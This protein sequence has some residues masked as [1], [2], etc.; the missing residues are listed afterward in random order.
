MSDSGVVSG[1]REVETNH[2]PRILVDMSQWVAYSLRPRV[3]RKLHSHDLGPILVFTT[4]IQ[5]LNLTK[6]AAHA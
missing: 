1:L 4:T 5:S 3:M 6:E 2:T